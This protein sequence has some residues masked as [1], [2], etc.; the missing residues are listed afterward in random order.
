MSR[1]PSFFPLLLLHDALP[2][3]PS[4]PSFPSHCSPHFVSLHFRNTT[5]HHSV[6]LAS[7]IFSYVPSV[8]LFTSVVVPLALLQ[9]KI[10][11]PT[12]QPVYLQEGDMLRLVCYS[13]TEVYKWHVWEK[14]GER[15]DFN[16]RTSFVLVTENQGDFIVSTLKKS[17]VTKA[18]EGNYSCNPLDEPNE[19]YNVMVNVFTRE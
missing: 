9:S 8:H 16:T 7:A 5:H 4:I 19:G 10:V 11:Q 2:S 6:H 13:E 3:A 12:I 18:D 17:M 1:G 15:I 14:N